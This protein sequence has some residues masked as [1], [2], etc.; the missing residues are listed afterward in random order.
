VGRA[1]IRRAGER[2]RKE[3]EMDQE[4]EVGDDLLEADVV[5]DDE[6]LE[7]RND[8]SYTGHACQTQPTTQV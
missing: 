1:E 4:I 6:M 3:I 7:A 8:V 2:R 5:G